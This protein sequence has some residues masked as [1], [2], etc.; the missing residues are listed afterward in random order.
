MGY[1]AVV[2]RNGGKADFVAFDRNSVSSFFHK[3]DVRALYEESLRASRMEWSDNFSKQC[4][5]YSLYQLARHAVR[6]HPELDAAECG[7][8]KGH[9][10]HFVSTL[11]RRGG[12]KGTFHVFD[13]FEGGLSALSAHDKNER[14]EL[15]PAQVKA[16]KEL[17]ASTE[18]EVRR[19]LQPFPFAKLYKGWIPERFAEVADRKFSFVHIDVDLYEPIRDSLAFFF[20][21]LAEGGALVLDDYGFAEFP[22][23]KKAADEYLADK[24]VRFFFE[25]P[26]GGAFLIK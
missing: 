3:D 2:F 18:E 25:S 26:T 20:P 13:S 15:T 10:T 1:K 17:F 11:L 14:Y 21:R 16:Q 22:G 6:D 19:V 9:S 12:F 7:C 24:K 23:A 5:F 4:R 8:W